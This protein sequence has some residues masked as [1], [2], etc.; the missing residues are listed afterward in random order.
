MRIPSRACAQAMQPRRP[1]E[2]ALSCFQ[3][4]YPR[5]LR[6]RGL[7]AVDLGDL[8]TADGR[9][10]GDGRERGR[11][12]LI[13]GLLGVKLDRLIRRRMP[14]ELV[15]EG[16]IGAGQL[17]PLKPRGRFDFQYGF[18]DLQDIE[19]QTHIVDVLE[20]GQQ[21][22]RLENAGDL[23]PQMLEVREGIG[24]QHTDFAFGGL[25]KTKYQRRASERSP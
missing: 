14:P 22:I 17:Q 4:Y 13:A 12:K 24:A 6:G 11:L 15:R 21:A 3:A 7:S 8:Q 19:R 25:E 1:L 10:V 23:P 18:D 16:M 5:A 20:P 9:A 2:S